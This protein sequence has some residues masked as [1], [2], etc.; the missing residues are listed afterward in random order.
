MDIEKLTRSVADKDRVDPWSHEF[1][2]LTKDE[3]TRLLAL[4]R[5]EALEEAAVKAAD[6]AQLAVK[7]YEHDSTW[8]QP[9]AGNRIRHVGWNTADAIRSMKEVKT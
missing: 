7:H 4:V 5:N 3:L 9:Y 2:T 6:I 8:Y 1:C